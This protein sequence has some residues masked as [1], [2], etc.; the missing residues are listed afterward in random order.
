[1]LLDATQ[2]GNITVREAAT[3]K[4][5]RVLAG[6]GA[7]SWA[8]TFAPG[9]RRLL[10]TRHNETRLLTWPD[11]AVVWQQP[12]TCLAAFSPDVKRL[13]SGN[14]N[15]KTLFRDPQS[16][17]VLSELPGASLAAAAFSPDGRRLATAH[18]YGAWRVRDGSSGGVLKEVQEFEHVFGLAFSP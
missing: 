7:R 14:W 15:R 9:G 4:A 17:A 10:A 13:V 3:G 6:S 1:L 8:L 5:V 18:I 16:G 12:D 11:G 2:D